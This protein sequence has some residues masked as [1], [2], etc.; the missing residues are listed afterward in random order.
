MKYLNLVILSL[1]LGACQT[2]SFWVDDSNLHIKTE[3]QTF[4]FTEQAKDSLS[5]II[6]QFKEDHGA[7]ELYFTDLLVTSDQRYIPHPDIF[8][9]FGNV[10]SNGNYRSILL[11]H[12]KE[13]PENHFITNQYYN[14]NL[15]DAISFTTDSTGSIFFEMHYVTFD[16]LKVS[17]SMDFFPT[18][19]FA[20]DLDVPHGFENVKLKEVEKSESKS[21]RYQKAFH[22]LNEG[23]LFKKCQDHLTQYRI[24]KFPSFEPYFTISVI[25]KGDQVILQS[26]R[27]IEA[28]YNNRLAVEYIEKEKL[29]T[30]EQWIRFQNKIETSAFWEFSPEPIKYTLSND[31][32]LQYTEVVGTDGAMWLIEGCKLG[33]YHTVDRWSGH[34]ENHYR[35]LYNFLTQLVKLGG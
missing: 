14:D 25:D 13:F 17:Y 28:P 12:S 22:R 23:S 27:M 5:S 34:L 33:E 26:K 30:T 8:D 7:N 24:S 19:I 4:T 29:L 35:D 10:Y 11:T 3:K 15:Y 1:F 32:T 9:H 6:T 2:D 18:L 31:S 16:T 21:Q 20:R